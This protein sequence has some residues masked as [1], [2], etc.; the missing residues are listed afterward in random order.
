MQQV[1]HD[2]SKT[3]NY[4]QSKQAT[5]CVNDCSKVKLRELVGPL[6]LI[7]LGID[8]LDPLNQ[9]ITGQTNRSKH[10]TFNY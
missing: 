4:T 3:Y 2:K 8:F 5:A 7:S 1:K 6:N 9:E 10:L